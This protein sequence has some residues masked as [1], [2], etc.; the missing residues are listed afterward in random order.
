LRYH[1]AGAIVSQLLKDG[2]IEAAAINQ[3]ECF[4]AG[5]KF[6]QTEGVIPAPEATHGIAEVIRQAKMAD[7]EGVSKTI[8]FNL[9]GHGHF[10]LG[11]YEQYLSGKLEDYEV[12]QEDIESSLAQLKALGVQ[13]AV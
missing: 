10:D 6:S 7:E 13:E 9:S 11:A 4:E 2:I 3:K 5:I 8:L 12:T 1:G